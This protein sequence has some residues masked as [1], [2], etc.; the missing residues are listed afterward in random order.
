MARLFQRLLY[1]SARHPEGR[2]KSEQN[3]ARDRKQECPCQRRTVH[4]QAAEQRQGN[5]SLMRQIGRRRESK[6]QPEN[7]AGQ[8][9]H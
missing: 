7:R 6:T 2:R 5:G 9:K 3:T 8:R 1:V 4:S